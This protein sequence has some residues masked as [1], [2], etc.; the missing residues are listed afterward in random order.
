[1]AIITPDYTIDNLSTILDGIEN[2]EKYIIEFEGK[3]T[4]MI[5]KKEYDSLI[6]TLHILSEPKMAKDIRDAQN[7]PTSEMI[8][9]HART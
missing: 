8:T 5:S 7:T 4:V 9:W 1:M 2:G 6:E 3:K